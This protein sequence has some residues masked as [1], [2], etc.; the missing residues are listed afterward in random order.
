MAIRTGRLR[1][2]PDNGR[3]LLRTGRAGVGSTIGH[4]LTIEVTDWSVELDI[5]DTGPTD[6][7]ATA[8]IELGSLA[9]REGTGGA[10]PLSDKDRG[11]IENNARRTLD[12]GRH[13]TA[14]F[15]STHVVTGDDHATISGTLTLHGVAAPIDVDVREVTPDRYRAATVVP[16]SSYG[17]K[18]YSALFG[19]IKVRDDV[20]VEIEVN[21][22][23]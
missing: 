2:G 9:V 20:E 8:R 10:R 12:V 16:Q 17:I 22:E 11:E 19:A 4:D 15:E 21:L 3:M 7:T 13:P 6:A 1:F 5:P 14:T 18:P 23:G